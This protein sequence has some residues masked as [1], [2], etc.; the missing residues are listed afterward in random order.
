MKVRLP[1]AHRAAIAA[2]QML[3]GAEGPRI[4]NLLES[5]DTPDRALFD[6]MI[7]DMGDGTLVQVSWAGWTAQVLVEVV[8]VDGHRIYRPH[9]PVLV[10]A[11]PSTPTE[12]KSVGCRSPLREI[13]DEE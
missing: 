11:R 9:A 8:T 7:P 2:L 12:F 10:R 3:L 4:D 1:A 13:L 5:L 6:R